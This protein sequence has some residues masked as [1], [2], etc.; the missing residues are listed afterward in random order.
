MKLLALLLV[1]SFCGT[2]GTAENVLVVVNTTSALSRSIG[3]YYARRRS[4]PLAQICRI[5]TK[6]Q[7]TIARTVYEKEIEPAVGRCLTQSKLTEKILYIVL[8]Q[9]VPLRISGTD[10]QAGEAAS[11]DSELTLLYP[12]LK[13]TKFPVSGAITNP[14]F[15]K[16][17]VEFRH[18]DVPL[19]LV[20][21]LAAFDFNGVKGMIDRSLLAK[22]TGKF[23][24]D[25][26][27]A[28]GDGNEW[29]KD[30]AIRLPT[31]R[32]VFDDGK[33][34]LS[35]LGDVIGYA[36][37][38]SND[39]NHSRRRPGFRWL[40]GAIVTEYVSTDGRTFV[41][42]PASWTVSKKWDKPSE[43]YLGSPQSLTA[44]AIEDGATG[45]S[46]HVWEPYLKFT[47]RPDIL[48]P[49]YYSGRNLAESYYLAIVGLSWQNIVIGDPLCSLGKPR[50]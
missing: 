19:Y 38:G 1:A 44:D 29:L 17:T 25:G 35:G 23:V 22:N 15:G 4:I 6:E 46:G 50:D 28:G 27:D 26:N 34:V 10:G 32:T 33:A 31:A 12:K 36:S 40:P 45:A 9:G 5:Q 30:A 3:E 41:R 39:G 14:F 16:T 13:G 49:A 20:T 24:L 37:W 7:E 8:T 48:L 18:P 2:A 47:P 11:V 43:W 42:P 21:R